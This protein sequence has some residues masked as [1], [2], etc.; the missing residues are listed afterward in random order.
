MTV[1][2]TLPL[3]ALTIALQPAHVSAQ[4]TISYETGEYE[5]AQALPELDDDVVTETIEAAAADQPVGAARS[6]PAR[7]ETPVFVPS[8]TI[9]PIDPSQPEYYVFEQT[10]AQ[11]TPA[12]RS[13]QNRSAVPAVQ[14]A[15]PT[16][17]YIQ[18]PPQ[19]VYV[20]PAQQGMVTQAAGGA[21]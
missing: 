17:V 18:Q 12:V 6:I 13:I 15:Q 16:Y 4:N 10:E 3:I 7:A 5:Y 21:S 9:Q 11:P 1:R 20:Y 19:V 2:T 14:Q 8:P